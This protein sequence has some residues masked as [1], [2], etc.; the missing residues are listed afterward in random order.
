MKNLCSENY[1]TSFFFFWP[2]HAACGILIPWPGIKLTPPAAEARSLKHWTA[3]KVP[4]NYKTLMKEI[5]GDINRWK[6]IPYLWIE[7]INVVKISILPNA[8][9]RFS[10]IP[11]MIPMEFFTKVEKTLLKFIWNCKRPLIAKE[12]VRKKNKAGGIRLSDFK[13]YCKL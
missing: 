10:A 11:I 3:R 6:C 2:C 7:R 1:K 13:L 4:E 12:N 9:C 5:E 8:I